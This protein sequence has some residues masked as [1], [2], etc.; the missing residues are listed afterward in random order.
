MKGGDRGGKLLTPMYFKVN[1]TDANLY[2]DNLIFRYLVEG[3]Y[4]IA[5]KP[6]VT[7]V[8]IT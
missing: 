5:F 8:P 2:F 7:E 1:K 6:S 3:R 4:F